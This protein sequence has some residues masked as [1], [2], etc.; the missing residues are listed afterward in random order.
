MSWG[1]VAGAVISA[2]VG[3]MSQKDTNSANAK[4]AKQQGH[5][6]MTTT[7][8]PYGPASPYLDAGAQSAYD[9]LYGTQN[10]PAIAGNPNA[11]PAAG[12]GGGTARAGKGPSTWTN[13]KGQT[14]TLVNGK[15]VPTTAG[16]ATTTV[17]GG[18]GGGAPSTVAGKSGQSAATSSIIGQ[19]QGLPGQNAGM[20][21]TAEKYTT[22][23]LQGRS[24]NPLLDPAAAAAQNVQNDPRL[25]AFEDYLM[26]GLGVGDGSGGGSGQPATWGGSV[27]YGQPGYAA[28]TGGGYGSGG[29]GYGSATGTDAALRALVAGKDPA[30]WA[31]MQQAIRDSVA[32][33]RAATLRE[34]K[35]KGVAGGFYGGSGFDEM[36]AQAIASG[37]NQLANQLATARFGAYQNALQEGTQY[38][39]GMADVAARD[40]ATSASAGASAAANAA[41]LRGQNLGALGSALQLGEEGRYGTATNL[42]SL[43]NLFSGDQKTALGGINDLAASRRGDLSAAGQLALGSDQTQ[44]SRAAAAMSANASRANTNAQIAWQQQQFYDPFTR[45]QDY[46]QILGNLYGGYGSQTEQGTDTRAGGGAGYVSPFGSALQGAAIGGQ[47]GS[48]FNNRQQTADPSAAAYYTQTAGGTFT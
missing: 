21:T 23:L 11:A 14:M 17:G 37:D 1:I 33:D 44:N 7:R 12:G 36:E 19:M 25:S 26:S 16:P 2:G 29:A 46:T 35:G 15:A 47:L 20:N 27:A 13:A 10:G 8:S 3:Y 48:A 32:S 5:V 4:L 30:G 42:G 28:A 31:D 22:D 34:L 18:A 40:R 43:A 9:A 38:D 45:L 41:A 6:D 39:L 24:S